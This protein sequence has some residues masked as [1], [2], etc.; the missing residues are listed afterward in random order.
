MD[1][2]PPA[3][4]YVE[5]RGDRVFVDGTPADGASPADRYRAALQR[6]AEAVA[7]PQGRPVPVWVGDSTV[8]INRVWVKPDGSCEPFDPLPADPREAAVS[9]APP[10]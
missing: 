4:V 10:A 6:V 5:L 1:G 7:T 2:R 8:V 3:W 9:G